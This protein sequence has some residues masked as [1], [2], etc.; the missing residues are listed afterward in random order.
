VKRD[1]RIITGDCVEA[2]RALAPASVDAIV[3]DPPYGIGFMGREWDTFKPAEVKRQKKR[4]TRTQ[5]RHGF[6]AGRESDAPSAAMAAARYDLSASANRRFQEWFTVWAVEALR[7][8]KPGGHLLAFGGTRTFHRLACAL[9]DAGFEIRDCLSWLYGSGFP[10][11]LDGSKAIDADACRADLAA[12]LGRKPTR[13]EFKAA[14]AGWREVV[15]TRRTEKGSGCTGNDFLARSARSP[16]VDVTAPATPA[17]AQWEGWGTALKPAW[18]PVILARKPLGER[19]V[20]LNLLKH[21]TGALNVDGC[22]IGTGEDTLRRGEQNFAQW[23]EMEGREDRPVPVNG[24]GGNPSGRFP[25]NLILDEESAALVDRQSG[26][27]GGTASGYNFADSRND[28]AAHVTHNIKSGVH[29]GDS[30]GASRFFYCAKASRAERE[31]GLDG[32]PERFQDEAREPGSPGGCNPRN[33]GAESKVLNHHPTVKPVALMR[34]L[35]RLV[36]P[37]GG[38]VLDPFAGSGTTGMAAA[39]E[40]FRFLGIEKEPE[41]VAIA[42]RRIAYARAN[43]RAFDDDPPPAPVP[44]A[45]GQERLFVEEHP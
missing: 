7:V 32:L 36:T 24:T 43:P 3:C 21:G 9:E 11:S 35:V 6:Y 37:P 34:W 16:I 10:K 4:D 1:S 33:R 44:D 45:P 17:A 26:E 29:F 25:A 8:L 14:W 30:G 19:N 39:L 5:R 22:R 13:V 18:E 12:R 40:G 41:Y 15:G 27:S 20:A 2:M 42:E 28:N 23:R 31:A 38:L